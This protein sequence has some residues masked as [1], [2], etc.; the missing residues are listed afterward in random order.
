MVPSLWFMF[1]LI[2]DLCFTCE[3]AVDP[4]STVSQAQ[5]TSIALE[6]LQGSLEKA[7]KSKKEL[8]TFKCNSG[9]RC[10]FLMATNTDVYCGQYGRLYM[11]Y[12]SCF[13]VFSCLFYWKTPD[14]GGFLSSLDGAR[15]KIP[16]RTPRRSQLKPGLS[17][18]IHWRFPGVLWTWFRD[19]PGLVCQKSRLFKTYGKNSMFTG[20]GRF[21]V[22][23][24]SRV[25]CGTWNQDFASL[26]FCR[27]LLVAY[28]TALNAC[29]G[30]SEFHWRQIPFHWRA[31]L[32]LSIFGWE[33][34]P[35]I[36][37]VIL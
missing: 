26:V 7:V 27:Q 18:F 30:V 11:W 32:A 20:I 16:K 21:F 12:V 28:N 22:L 29:A 13:G 6:L 17:G 15:W 34:R 14:L 4:T 10:Y 36:L 3:S 23:T 2:N 5:Q 24:H 25:D 1:W 31:G 9:F 37:P 35:S 33:G 19:D 8:L